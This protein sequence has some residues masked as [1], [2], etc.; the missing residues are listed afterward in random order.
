MRPP[1]RPP[2][3]APPPASWAPA[4]GRQGGTWG[5][6][7]LGGRAP[8]RA[9]ASSRLASRTQVS[10]LQRAAF[11]PR[12]KPHGPRAGRAL[13]TQDPTQQEGPWPVV[14]GLPACLTLR[15]PQP[16]GLLP[17][18]IKPTPTCLRQNPILTAVPPGPPP[19]PGPDPGPTPGKYD[20]PAAPVTQGTPDPGGSADCRAR[21]CGPHLLPLP[22]TPHPSPAPRGAEQDAAPGALSEDTFPET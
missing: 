22:Q 20:G 14:A 10:S 6:P 2:T 5:E 1:A 18:S 8:G 16:A 4:P 19:R 7:E 12:D 15:G 11:R 21:V 13:W 9:S 3:R 17:S